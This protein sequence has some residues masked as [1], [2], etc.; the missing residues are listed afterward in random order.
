MMFDGTIHDMIHKREN[1]DCWNERNQLKSQVEVHN[2]IR[3]FIFQRL[4]LLPAIAVLFRLE[5]I[6]TKSL[7]GRNEDYLIRPMPPM[8]W[9]F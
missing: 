4:P 1:G 5:A 3:R 9:L 8:M 7:L 6:R 2:T